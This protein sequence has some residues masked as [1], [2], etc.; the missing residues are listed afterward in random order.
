MKINCRH[1][2]PRWRMHM[3]ITNGQLHVLQH[4]RRM[5]VCELIS[6]TVIIFKP[7]VSALFLSVDILCLNIRNI[8]YRFSHGPNYVYI[9]NFVIMFC[10]LVRAQSR[11]LTACDAGSSVVTAA[12]RCQK[13]VIASGSRSAATVRHVLSIT[14]PCCGWFPNARALDSL[15]AL[16]L[17]A[18]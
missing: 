1:F 5:R 16:L 15:L 13:T 2:I 3:C 18:R 7:L 8:Y 9:V 17:P 4:N 6:S 14:V 12:T 10:S 11:N